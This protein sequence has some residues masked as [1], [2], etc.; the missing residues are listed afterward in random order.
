MLKIRSF[1]S[2]I[3]I[4]TEHLENLVCDEPKII[5]EVDFFTGK[6]NTHTH[7]NDFIVLRASMPSQLVLMALLNILY[8]SMGQVPLL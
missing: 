6:K 1:I 5:I 2:Y 8:S 3:Y 4:Y 7:M